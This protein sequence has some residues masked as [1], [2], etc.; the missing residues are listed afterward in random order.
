[1]TNN[2]NTIATYPGFYGATYVPCTVAQDGTARFPN[3]KPL[4]RCARVLDGAEL[5]DYLAGK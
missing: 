4:P 3:G 1:M 2:G 5:A